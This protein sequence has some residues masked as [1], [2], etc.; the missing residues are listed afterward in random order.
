M[1]TDKDQLKRFKD[2][3]KEAECDESDS[4]LDK[5]FKKIDPKTEHSEKK[6]KP[7]K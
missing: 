3:A 5:A 2:A 6:K 1:T 4:A 7:K